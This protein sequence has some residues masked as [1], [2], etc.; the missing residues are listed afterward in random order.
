[1]LKSSFCS[2]S[3]GKDSCLALFKAIN[4]GYDV[5]YLLTMMSDKGNISRSHGI[6][7]KLLFEQSDRLEIKMIQKYTSWEDYEN[8]FISTLNYFKKNN[9]EYG[10]FGDIDIQDH[11]DW[12]MKICNKTNMKYFEPLWKYKRV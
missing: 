12:V 6:N 4:Q 5:K 11:L 10:I 9:I 8:V 2:W 7:S 1:M 3:G